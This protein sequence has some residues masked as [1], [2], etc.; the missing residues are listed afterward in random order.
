MQS[1]HSKGV[2]IIM[3]CYNSASRLETTLRFLANQKL[4][5]STHVELI[6]VNNASTDDTSEKAQELWKRYGAPYPL[7]LVNESTPGLSFARKKGLSTASFDVVVFCDDD[8]WLNENYIHHAFQVM[9]SHPSVG[10]AGGDS[11]GIYEKEPPLWVQSVE[12]AYAIGIQ[13]EKE[14]L[15][16]GVLWGAGLVVRKSVWEKLEAAGFESLLS[17]RTETKLTSGEDDELCLAAILAGYDIFYSRS[18]QLHHYITTNRI[19]KSYIKNL[20]KATAY[21]VIGLEPYLKVLDPKTP[22]VFRYYQSR[23]LIK[24]VFFI[25]MQLITFKFFFR[26]FN[27][28]LEKQLNYRRELHKKYLR[29]KYAVQMNKNFHRIQNLK[30]YFTAENI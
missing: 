28:N 10:I 13:K 3:C 20:Y 29:W 9:V 2:S 12:R 14:G 15:F 19:S 23:Y 4:D 27:S 18:L 8:N 1:N 21:S 25:L 22:E 30:K 7:K 17:G 6:I 26:Y 11:F 24:F 16:K 5:S